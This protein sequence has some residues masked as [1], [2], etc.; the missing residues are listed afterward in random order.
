MEGSSLH[1]GT[2]LKVFI[3]F[4]F[5]IMSIVFAA[6]ITY[7]SYNEL[8]SAV[9]ELS[10]PDTR[11]NQLGNI[12]TEVTES[13]SNIRAYALTKEAKYLK[14]YKRLIADVNARLDTLMTINAI[15]GRQA[16]QM[17]SLSNLLIGKIKK[18]DAYLKSYRRYSSTDIADKAIRKI[19]NSKDSLE[20][21]YS[22][23]TTTTTSTTLDTLTFVY[24]NK[25]DEVKANGFYRK[26]KNLFS[27]KKSDKRE[28]WENDSIP[29]AVSTE[30]Q[31]TQDTSVLIP[32]DTAIINSVK[33]LLLEVRREEYRDQRTKINQELNMM[34]ENTLILH[35]I[36]QIINALGQ[37]SI[38]MAEEKKNEA[39]IVAKMATLKIIFIILLFFIIVLIFGILISGDITK[40]DFYKRQLEKAKTKAEKLAEVKESFLANMS[41]EIRTPL[42]AII[43]FSEQLSKTD[44][45]P[46]QNN[47][48]MAVGNASK[49]LLSTVNDILDFSKIE[50]GKLHIERIPFEIPQE[51]NLV[52]ET[53]SLRAKE[54]GIGLSVAFTGDAMDVAVLGDAFRFR[55]ILFNLVENAIKFTE[56]GQVEINTSIIKEAEG[57]SLTLKVM[58]TGIG[59]SEDKQSTIFEDFNQADT[60]S[61]RKYGGSGLGLS[62][63]R[64]LAEL[65]GGSISLS[66]VP[67]KGSTFV[68]ALHY[69]MADTEAIEAMQNKAYVECEEQC[70]GHHVLIVE[71]D[72]FNGMLT[73]TLLKKWGAST[74]LCQDGKSALRQISEQH[75]DLLLTDLH[76]P[77]LSGADLTQRIRDM[78]DENIS[79]IPILVLTADVTPKK[80]QDCLDAGAD[81]HLLKPYN[82]A[83]LY[84][85]VLGLL[86]N[87][88]VSNIERVQDKKTEQE[89]RPASFYMKQFAIKKKPTLKNTVVRLDD[90][91]KFVSGDEEAFLQLLKVFLENALMD[92]E[93]LR[94]AASRQ[95]WKS[96]QQISHKLLTPFGQV[97]AKKVT[98]LLVVLE[99][100]LEEGDAYDELIEKLDQE[101]EKVLAVMYHRQVSL[102]EKLEIR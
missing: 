42:N 94:A 61:T 93:A 29:L 47:Y 62:I 48:L 69:A 57:I 28:R 82:E 77:E 52:K 87:G 32:P 71:D 65:M 51:V 34:K 33:Q 80:L 27:K 95:E 43:G 25:S 8:L 31:V 53:L 89:E 10:R 99:A 35:Q 88:Q 97:R 16:D 84:Q 75:Y 79:R 23:T 83:A 63:C 56:K 101:A 9:E 4:A 15:N 73:E 20:V 78:E 6:W 67:E 12:L 39:K 44:F 46:D 85:Q 60:S 68:L 24:D 92:L 19:D 14:T 7:R 21:S 55:Q 5:A 22:I 3:G 26:L 66:S 36:R 58:D 91:E 11:A 38:L 100:P 98:A 76:M 18:L 17:D 74:T 30:T 37:E 86:G 90:L 41:H 49:H 50:A 45:N 96:V 54:K 1:T 13:E 59:I 2:K 70:T 81:A 102:E 40:I 64:K 72:A